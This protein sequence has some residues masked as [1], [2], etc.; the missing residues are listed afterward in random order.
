MTNLTF[1]MFKHRQNDVDLSYSRNVIYRLCSKI[2]CQ[3]HVTEIIRFSAQ[4]I[5]E[6]SYRR[7]SCHCIRVINDSI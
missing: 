3:M 7:K 6:H 1:K 4:W 5:L 2:H